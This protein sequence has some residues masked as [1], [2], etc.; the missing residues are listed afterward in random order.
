MHGY[1]PRLLK[2]KE[3]L[4]VEAIR[5]RLQYVGDKIAGEGVIGN[6]LVQSVVDS[7]PK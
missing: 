1:V 3:R 6:V 7:P 5:T 2:K 4:D